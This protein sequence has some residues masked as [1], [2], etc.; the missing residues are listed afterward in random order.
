MCFLQVISNAGVINTLSHL[1]PPSALTAT[2][3]LQHTLDKAKALA[4]KHRYSEQCVLYCALEEERVPEFAGVGC[5]H[6]HLDYDMSSKAKFPTDP[7]QRL[8]YLYI[9]CCDGREEVIHNPHAAAK[10]LIG[11]SSSGKPLSTL[12]VVT[13]VSYDWFSKWSD[14]KWRHRGN[15]YKEYKEELKAETLAEL[16]V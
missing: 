12:Q 15:G 5:I 10:D 2:P 16:G 9:S 4:R 3:A 1:V 7:N 6:R 13:P 8:N 11:S 14:S